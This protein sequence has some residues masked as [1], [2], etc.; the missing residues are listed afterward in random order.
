MAYTFSLAKG[1]RVGNSLVE[2]DKVDLAKELIAT[3][4]N[5]KL[6]LPLDTHCATALVGDSEKKI[7][8]AGQIPD[9]FEG[10]DIGPETSRAYAAVVKGAKTVVWNGPM[11]VFEV[12]PFDAGTK[13]IAQAIAESDAVSIIGGGDSAA[14]I[15]RLGY[16]DQVTH[17]STGGGA[18]LEML[19]GKKFKTVEILDN[20]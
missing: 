9:G 3:G 13:A 16:A 11:G 7:V 12:P 4:A 15:E 17:V 8:P 2:K 1:N 10:L 5:Q 14:A 20:A 19:E 18:S 6:M